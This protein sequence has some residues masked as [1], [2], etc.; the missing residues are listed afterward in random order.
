MVESGSTTTYTGNGHPFPNWLVYDSS[1]FEV[2]VNGEPAKFIAPSPT[3]PTYHSDHADYGGL[4]V[5][6]NTYPIGHDTGFNLFT[7]IGENGYVPEAPYND[8]STYTDSGGGEAMLMSVDGDGESGNLNDFGFDPNQPLYLHNLDLHNMRG[9]PYIDY[10]IH[11]YPH[12]RCDNLN[13]TLVFDTDYQCWVSH[14]GNPVFNAIL[15]WRFKILHSLNNNAPVFLNTYD[16]RYSYTYMYKE[17]ML[18]PLIT[19][20]PNSTD[21]TKVEVHARS[22]VRNVP[23]D[24]SSIL[25]HYKGRAITAWPDVHQYLLDQHHLVSDPTYALFGTI[26][27]TNSTLVA[28][29][30]NDPAW[31][32]LNTLPEDYDPIQINYNLG[33]YRYVDDGE[34]EQPFIDTDGVLEL[35]SQGT[36]IRYTGRTGTWHV[37]SSDREIVTVQLLYLVDESNN[38]PEMPG[39]TKDSSVNIYWRGWEEHGPAYAFVGFSLVDPQLS[40]KTPDMVV[41][42]DTSYINNERITAILPDVKCF[43]NFEEYDFNDFSLYANGKLIEPNFRYGVNDEI[44]EVSYYIPDLDETLNYNVSYMY[45]SHT[46]EDYNYHGVTN[47]PE[48]KTFLLDGNRFDNLDMNQETGL[49]N[50]FIPLHLQ[51]VYNSTIPLL[52][53]K[54]LFIYVDNGQLYHIE[55]TATKNDGIYLEYFYSSEGKT[56]S[57]SYAPKL[58]TSNVLTTS[59]AMIHERD[60]IRGWKK[61]GYKGPTMSIYDIYI[62]KDTIGY[63]IVLRDEEDV[64]NGADTVIS[65]LPITFTAE[66]LGGVGTFDIIINGQKIASNISADQIEQAFIDTEKLIVEDTGEEVPNT[67]LTPH[68]TGEMELDGIF[69]VYIDGELVLEDVTADDLV[70]ATEI[71]EVT[72]ITAEYVKAPEPPEPE[73]T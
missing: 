53:T 22:L 1:L 49:F 13:I 72:S 55:D 3:Y 32:S 12:I 27:P 7:N 30:N 10:S 43:P 21:P 16:L 2:K 18:N 28:R 38:R 57:L 59:L 66:E 5:P 29:I 73:A 37:V 56:A 70:V 61:S 65:P 35:S 48:N 51:W 14:D 63:P 15:E 6:V 42:T 4:Y 47:P 60:L 50:R 67:L 36:V 41:K 11:N 33:Y 45:T 31:I 39:S 25:P 62:S 44:T 19:M 64:D 69:D 26:K 9:Q 58:D 54:P 46:L 71:D 68:V 52:E 17:S 23:Y 20:V 40:S 8:P 34:V 24:R